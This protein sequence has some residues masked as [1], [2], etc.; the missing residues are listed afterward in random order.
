MTKV[1]DIVVPDLG[2][3]DNVEVIEVLVGAGDGFLFEHQPALDRLGDLAPLFGDLLRRDPVARYAG[4]VAD[5]S[6]HVCLLT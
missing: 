3:F 6:S 1:I 4:S 5:N 2:D